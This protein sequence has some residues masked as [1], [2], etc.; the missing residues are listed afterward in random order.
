MTKFSLSI[1]SNYL[2]LVCPATEMKNKRKL[3]KGEGK[4]LMY[5]VL[6][7]GHP[8]P[9]PLRPGAAAPGGG[10]TGGCRDAGQARC[11]KRS[12]GSTSSHHASARRELRDDVGGPRQI[13]RLKRMM[14]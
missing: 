3:N 2:Q 1:A 10:L 12:W 9:P 5:C 4:G 11:T 6:M 13:P 14:S 8:R 7:N